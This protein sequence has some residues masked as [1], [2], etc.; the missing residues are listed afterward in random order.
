MP[1]IWVFPQHMHLHHSC[2]HVNRL[3]MS[4]GIHG[5]DKINGNIRI[6]KYYNVIMLNHFHNPAGYQGVLLSS[7]RLLPDRREGQTMLPNIGEFYSLVTACCRIEKKGRQSGWISG[8][9]TLV[10]A[11]CRIEKKARQSCRISGSSTL[12]TA[13]CQIEKKARQSCRI[14]G[15]S[16]L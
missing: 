6:S 9:S 13:C 3:G 16:T 12:V 15:S 10:T 2:I 4:L 7:N 14:S 5:F 8:S 1:L 11:C